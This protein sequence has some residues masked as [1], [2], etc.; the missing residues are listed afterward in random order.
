MSEP[1][2]IT[3]KTFDQI[4][5]GDSASLSRKITLKDIDMFAEVTGDYN[6]AHMDEEFAAEGIFGQVVAHGMMTAGLVSAVLG[7]K[8]PGPGTIYLAQDMKFERPV[9][10]DDTI[11]ATVTVTEKIEKRG[12]LKLETICVNQDGKSV[13]SGTA[14]IKAPTEAVVWIKKPRQASS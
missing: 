6:P 2:T 1:E 3:N 7:T 11:T 14:T 5:V 8:L 10:P 13:L 4:S 12:F 9:L